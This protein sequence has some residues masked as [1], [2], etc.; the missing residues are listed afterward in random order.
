MGKK[1][2]KIYT[3]IIIIAFFLVSALNFKIL[4]KIDNYQEVIVFVLA[5][6]FSE[7]LSI[8]ASTVSNISFSF[9]VYFTIL[10]LFPPIQA[11][12]IV[13]FGVFFA[14]YEEEKKYRHILNSSIY[15]RLFNAASYFFT[16]YLSSLFFNYADSIDILRLGRFGIIALATTIL[17]YLFINSS[18][19]MGLFALLSQMSFKDM[20]LKNVWALKSFFTLSPIGIMM[21]LFY[22]GYG[23]FGL[24]LFFGPLF[25]ARY[26]FKLYLN[27]K[28]VYVETI[29]ALT[30]AIDAK[31]EYTNGHSKRVAE[32][33]VMLGKQVKL[34]VP[35]L[36]TLKTAGLLHDVGKIG[37]SDGILLKPG[38]LDD[39]EMN[40]IRNHPEIGAHIIDGIEFLDDARLFVS[41]HH[42][43]YDGKGYPNG[44]LGEEM[45]VESLI[46]AVADAFDAMTSDRSYRKAFSE[47]KALEI[48]QEEKNKQFSAEI[49]DA[50]MEIKNT[51]GS[52]MISVS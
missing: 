30:N 11:G 23:W 20:I 12:F 28:E 24:L 51:Q 43:R 18:I 7:L 16:V 25:L 2:V 15:K 37:I 1:S 46:L 8:E 49:V 27:M 34:S 52:V 21:L 39:F 41:Q 14:V 10:I 33:A 44:V 3:A 26:S 32:Y 17:L 13:A 40:L 5:V 35:R 31:D 22:T 50:M 38:K 4:F 6:V 42:E 9:A 36:E 47:E 45:P 48:L 29:T 19:F